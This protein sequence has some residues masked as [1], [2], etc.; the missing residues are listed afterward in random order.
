[1]VC[2]TNFGWKGCMKSDIEAIIKAG[3]YLER[4]DLKWCKFNLESDLIL[5]VP[6][7]NIKELIFYES[8]SSHEN[9]WNEKPEN[10]GR[11]VKAISNF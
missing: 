1:M 8:G 7:Y 9:K 6:E 10:F 2:K 11:I 3:S 5:N 4:I